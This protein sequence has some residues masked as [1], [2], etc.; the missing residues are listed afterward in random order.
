MNSNQIKSDTGLLLVTYN[1]FEHTKKV[2]DAIKESGFYHVNVVIDGAINSYDL[3]QQKKISSYISSSGLSFNLIKSSSNLGL[4]K[5][6][7]NSINYMFKIYDRLI[8]LEDDCVP[9]VKFKDFILRMLDFHERNEEIGAICGFHPFNFIN[10]TTIENSYIVSDRF[11]PWGWATWK[12]SWNLYE[13]SLIKLA[14]IVDETLVVNILGHDI[15][16]YLKKD[17]FLFGKSDIWSLNW[18]LSLFKNDLRVAY[19]V[20]SLVDNIGF[21]GTGVH[22]S[23]TDIFDYKIDIYNSKDD[24][25]SEIFHREIIQ[26]MQINSG[27]AYEK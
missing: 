25:L 24:N 15:S 3:E 19:P 27:L 5:S 12:K 2:I 7:I 22:S 14:S 8:I 4:A 16:N 23:K 18:I 20:E 10:K 6:I 17:T 26:F 9:N 13:E 1:R 21:D 11:L